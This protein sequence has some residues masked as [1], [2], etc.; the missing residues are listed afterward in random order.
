MGKDKVK[1]G[2]FR[3]FTAIVFKG[4]VDVETQADFH[5]TLT[6][7]KKHD[8]PVKV[9]GLA[10]TG[11]LTLSTGEMKDCGCCTETV[12]KTVRIWTIVLETP[13]AMTRR[14][15]E[16]AGFPLAM[17]LIRTH[18]TLRRPPIA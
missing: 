18:E 14:E 7:L 15:L 17:K 8:I 6:L 4:E 11:A 3:P 2:K 13:C 1:H 16:E 9:A 12:V 10:G 5:R